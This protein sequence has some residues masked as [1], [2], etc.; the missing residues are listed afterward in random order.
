M[1]ILWASCLISNTMLDYGQH[2]DCDP[3]FDGELCLNR[4]KPEETLVESRR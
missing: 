2:A 4:A 3:I 1:D